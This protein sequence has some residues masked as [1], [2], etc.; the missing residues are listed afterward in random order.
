MTTNKSTTAFVPTC[1]G[2]LAALFT[3]CA[4]LVGLLG[5][6][7]NAQI[8]KSRTIQNENT[9]AQSQATH[10]NSAQPADR[11]AIRPFHVSA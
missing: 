2:N 4:V 8:E 10:R 6:I 1:R 3:A 7:G 5:S 9:M 11:D